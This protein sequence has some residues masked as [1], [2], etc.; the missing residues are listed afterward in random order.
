LGKTEVIRVK[1]TSSTTNLKLDPDV[2]DKT[3]TVNCL[4]NGTALHKY[5]ST[6]EGEY[7]MKNVINVLCIIIRLQTVMTPF[8]VQ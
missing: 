5:I 7:V 3:P 6:A 1:S 4:T 8:K 2:V